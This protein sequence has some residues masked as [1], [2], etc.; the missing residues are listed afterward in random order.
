[1]M[2]YFN[3]ERFNFFGRFYKSIFHKQ[4]PEEK[5]NGQKNYQIEE[6]NQKHDSHII[7]PKGLYKQIY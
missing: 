2:D 3:K 6:N 5:K 7:R 1:M 4:K